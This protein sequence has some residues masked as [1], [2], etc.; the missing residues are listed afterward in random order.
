MSYH[1]VR[2]FNDKEVSF[3]ENKTKEIYRRGSE[4][5]FVYVMYCNE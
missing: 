4:K 3:I 2:K 5:N 1:R